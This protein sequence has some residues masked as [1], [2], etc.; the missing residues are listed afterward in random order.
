[1]KA[2]FGEA[3]KVNTT[4]WLFR[5]CE[6][7]KCWYVVKTTVAFFYSHPMIAGL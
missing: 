5:F 1:M 2:T 7:E 6:A 3:T 4:A